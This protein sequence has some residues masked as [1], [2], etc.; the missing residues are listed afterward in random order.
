[1]VTVTVPDLSKY[2]PVQVLTILL[3]LI[4]LNV[5][6][7]V[8]ASLKLKSFDPRALADFYLTR[9]IPMLGG[10]LL[11]YMALEAAR[12]L[13]PAEGLG[14]WLGAFLLGLG[15]IAAPTAI[16]LPLAARIKDALEVIFDRAPAQTDPRASLVIAVED[17][18]GFAP[19]YGGTVTAEEAAEVLAVMG[20]G[21]ED[22][23]AAQRVMSFEGEPEPPPAKG[24]G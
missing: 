2:L 12:G 9:V 4:A 18:R 13:V 1:M 6:T 17:R 20:W 22:L 10:Y 24:E 7:A 16:I 21:A 5:L 8:L 19:S 11:V 14:S 23:L 3:I 15:D